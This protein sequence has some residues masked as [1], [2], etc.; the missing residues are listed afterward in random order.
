MT[1]ISLWRIILRGL[2]WPFRVIRR[3]VDGFLDFTGELF[4][5]HN[6]RPNSSLVFRFVLL[7]VFITQVLLQLVSEVKVPFELMILTLVGSF[8]ERFLYTWMRGQDRKAEG[9][10]GRLMALGAIE[11]IEPDTPVPYTVAD[12]DVFADRD[13]VMAR[14][15]DELER[16]A[17]A[18]A[19]RDTAPESMPGAFMTLAEAKAGA[20]R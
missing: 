8:G 14:A 5:D 10:P 2:L 15:R 17:R 7:A 12:Q 13:E 9:M 6:G 4:I 1:A 16:Q 3:V 20:P 19:E 11:G 18:R